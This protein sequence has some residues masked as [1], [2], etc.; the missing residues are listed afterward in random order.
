MIDLVKIGAAFSLIIVVFLRPRWNLGLVMFAA[1]L[2]PGTLYRIGPFTQ[3]KVLFSSGVDPV[4]IN[5]V[6]GSC[7]SWSWKTS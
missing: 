3:A 4:T 6:T 5:L 7:L 2:F 1:A